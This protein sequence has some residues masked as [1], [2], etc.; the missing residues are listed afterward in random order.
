LSEIFIEDQYWRSIADTL[1]PM[2]NAPQWVLQ[3]FTILLAL[4]LPIALIL[5]WAY[6]LT[7]SG[8]KLA[9]LSSEG[10][11]ATERAS[12]DANGRTDQPAPAHDP[13]SWIAVMPF[14]VDAEDGDLAR[15]GEGLTDSICA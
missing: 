15:L 8:V 9:K 14:K 13:R 6:D 1:L 11:A 3:A 12:D 4:G 2:F 7:P 10:E 5:A